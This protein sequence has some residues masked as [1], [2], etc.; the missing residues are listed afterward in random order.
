MAPPLCPQ[1]SP[2]DPAGG[3]VECVCSRASKP[4]RLRVLPFHRVACATMI[5]VPEQQ[6]FVRCECN[7]REHVRNA[8]AC[9]RPEIN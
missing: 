5:V 7:T 9:G 4:L 1:L 3:W 8:R 6:L 2:L